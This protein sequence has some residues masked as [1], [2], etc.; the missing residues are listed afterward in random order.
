M[1]ATSEAPLQHLN[2]QPHFGIPGQ[3]FLRAYTPGDDFY[4]ALIQTH[5]GLSDEQSQL[6]NARLVLLLAN[7]VG[8]LRVLR[9]AL[10]AAAQGV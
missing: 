4:E 2:T 5:Q 8:D 1:T 6:V 7:H 3:R 9:E 10:S